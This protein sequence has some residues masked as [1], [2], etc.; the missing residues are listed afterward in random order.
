ME[1]SS[2]L[3]VLETIKQENTFKD[4]LLDNLLTR[5]EWAEV[6]GIHRMTIMRWE[7]EIIQ[8]VSPI[9]NAYFGDS[10][11][12]RS[13]CLDNYQRFILACLFVVKGGLENC[14]KPNKEGIKFLKI[15]FSQL[16]REQFEEWIKYVQY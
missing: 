5:G 3:I 6:L 7:S 8:S 11:S 13:N 1:N 12:M 9:K 16:K 10:R 15:N 2:L 14:S 4:G